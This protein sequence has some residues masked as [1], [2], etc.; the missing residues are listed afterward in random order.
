MKKIVFLCMLFAMSGCL[1]LN[2]N[3]R[4]FEVDAQG[5][6]VKTGLEMYASGSGIYTIRNAFC[7]ANP[8]ATLRIINE[9]TGEELKSESPY[10]CR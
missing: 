10:K 6:P 7:A 4:L 5:K 9:D 8:K 3:Y 2:G 1:T